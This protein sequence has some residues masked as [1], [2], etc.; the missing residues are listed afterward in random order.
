[1]SYFS[2]DADKEAMEL[3]NKFKNG[4]HNDELIAFKNSLSDKSY[5]RLVDL[6]SDKIYSIHIIY[7]DEEMSR[8]Y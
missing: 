7:Y 2:T 6:I 1:M 4:L 8:N 3:L 5:K